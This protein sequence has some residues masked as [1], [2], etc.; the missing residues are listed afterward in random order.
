[1]T[2]IQKVRMDSPITHASASFGRHCNRMQ[3]LNT[4][5]LKY[6]LG[7]LGSKVNVP[8]SKQ[9]EIDWTTKFAC[10]CV[11]P[12]LLYVLRGG[13][14]WVSWYCGRNWASSTSHGWEM[15]EW[16]TVGMIIGRVTPKYSERVPVPL[17]PLEIPDGLSWVWTRTFVVRSW[18]LTARETPKFTGFPLWRRT[19]RFI[20]I[21][22][23]APTG[24]YREFSTVHTFKDPF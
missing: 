23:K 10:M 6:F 22:T 17:C 3:S 1:M 19:L 7:S 18:R 20:A 16:R 12:H 4:C 24:P 15:K 11:N 14:D 5:N 13:W 9:I 21:Y 2:S 8:I